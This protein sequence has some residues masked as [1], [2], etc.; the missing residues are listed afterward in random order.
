MLLDCAVIDS[1]YVCS[2]SILKK[3]NASSEA[4]DSYMMMP[5]VSMD[6]I[7]LIS[8]AVGVNVTPLTLACNPERS[9]EPTTV[10]PLNSARVP[11]MQQACPTV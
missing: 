4:L 11:D 5:L 9:Q 2:I 10:N 3:K 8:W 7:M 6:F 1:I